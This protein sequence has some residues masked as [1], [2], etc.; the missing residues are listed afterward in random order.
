[1]K[2]RKATIK[3]WMNLKGFMLKDVLAK[4]NFNSLKKA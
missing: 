1:M 3:D 2:I 4:L